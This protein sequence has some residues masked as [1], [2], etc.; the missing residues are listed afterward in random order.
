MC[1]K[2]M[3]FVNFYVNSEPISLK[4]YTGHYQIIL[5]NYIE[6]LKFF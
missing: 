4:F 5:Q 3:F 2:H 6:Y 1:L